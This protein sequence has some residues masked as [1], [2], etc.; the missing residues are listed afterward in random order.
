M[1]QRSW[2]MK[3]NLSKS[4]AEEQRQNYHS[5]TIQLWLFYPAVIV[6][7]HMEERGRIRNT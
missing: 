7:L 4:V 1:E 3:D 5:A 6:T 2:V